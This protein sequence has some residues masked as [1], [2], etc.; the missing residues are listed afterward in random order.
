MKKWTKED[1]NFIKNNYPVKGA[2][3][4]AKYLQ[5]SPEAVCNKAHS[6]KIHR[7][8]SSRYNRKDAPIGYTHCFACDNILPDGFFYKKNSSG[9]YGKKTNMCRSC[10]QKKSRHHYDKYKWNAFARRKKDPIHFIYIR[11]K[12]SAKKRKIHFDITEEELRSKFTKNCPI[13]GNELKFFSNSDWSPSVDRIDS[14]KGYTKNNIIIVSKKAN[15]LKNGCSVDDLRLL[16]NFYSSIVE[17][18]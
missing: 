2:G 17:G 15:V 16:Y 4:C 6:L 11:L 3:Y 18:N 7:D 8:G 1:I 9:K 14:R 10:S 12:S 5:R 13:Y